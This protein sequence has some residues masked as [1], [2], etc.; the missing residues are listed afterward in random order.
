M[1]RWECPTKL[2]LGKQLFVLTYVHTYEVIG[3]VCL[4]VCLSVC[5]SVLPQNIGGKTENRM[6]GVCTG[7]V[8]CPILRLPHFRMGTL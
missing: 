6:V 1:V 2:V 7:I 4:S 8:P 5:H 3:C